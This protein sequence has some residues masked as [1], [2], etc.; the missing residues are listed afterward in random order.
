MRTLLHNEFLMYDEQ[1]LNL[2][3]M[4][5]LET[6]YPGCIRKKECDTDIL[7]NSWY[8]CKILNFWMAIKRVFTWIVCLYHFSATCINRLEL[9]S[10]QRKKYFSLLR[11]GMHV[12]PPRPLGRDAAGINPVTL[13]GFCWNSFIASYISCLSLLKFTAIDDW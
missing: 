1:R 3:H 2:V 9:F 12:V 11:Q 10:I 5:I 4:E 13:Y 6:S 7:I 8:I